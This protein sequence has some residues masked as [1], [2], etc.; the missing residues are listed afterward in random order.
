MCAETI[1]QEPKVEKPTVARE[2]QPNSRRGAMMMALA[3]P[4]SM[5]AARAASPA[6]ATVSSLL[7][8]T[9]QQAAAFVSG[10]MTRW[11][12]LI[13]LSDDFTLMQPFGG[14]ASH[15]FD[16]SPEGLSKLAK[17]FRNGEA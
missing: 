10:D 9:E 17:A 15:G 7:Q 5:N 4:L 14:P 13:R 6:D 12:K 1:R 8:R 3:A 11:L 16:S 2:M